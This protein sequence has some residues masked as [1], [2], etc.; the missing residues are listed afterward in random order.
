MTQKK[1]KNQAQVVV[2]GGGV[3]GAS[4]LYHL[5]KAGWKDVVLVE[6][7]ELTHGSTWHSAGGMHTLNGDPNV[8]ALQKYTV[9]LYAEI[10][11]ISGR[12]CGI[13]LTGGL[14]LADSVE[15]MD[16]LRM[17]NARARYLGIDSHLISAA[18]AHEMVPFL[19][20]QYFEGA[21]FDAQEGHVDPSGVTHAYASS[22]Q[23]GGAEIY[24]NTWV[25]AI[26]QTSEGEWELHLHDTKTDEDL[27]TIRCEHFVNAGG[28][29]AR[30]VGRMA[31]IEIPVLAME[32][33][34]LLTEEGPE[35]EGWV[36]QSTLSGFHVMDLGG[37]IYLR[38]EG[39]GLLLGTY[40]P[41]G[42]PWS[43]QTTPWDFGAQ[44]LPPDLERIAA[45]LDVGFQHF[46]IFG[47]VGIKKTIN[48]PFTFAPDGNPLIGPVRGQRGH[49]LACAVMAGLSQGGGV[50]LAM[51]NWMTTGDPGFD[52]WGM[53]NAR[54]GDW[55]T[56]RYTN[57]K[58]RENYSRRFRIS[59]P[60]EELPAARG[61]MRS[62]IHGRLAA[63]NA[64]F[65]AAYGM[66]Y[67]RWFQAPGEEP[68]E[69]PT[70][71]R[72]NA[73]EMVG[74]EV[75][76]VRNRVGI[77]DITSYANYEVTGAGARNWLE[78]MM[79]NHMPDL[80]RLVLTPMLNEGGKLVGD[81]TVACLDTNRFMIIGSGSAQRYHERWFD[82]YAPH[83]GSA[84]IRA[85]GP[86]LAGLCVAGPRSRELLQG[87]VDFDISNEG[88]PF[89]QVLETWVDMVPV[90]LGR[91][92]FTGD[93]GYELW[94]RASYLPQ[95]FDTVM[96][97]GKP[98]GIRPFGIRA[99]ESMR[100]EK[101][102]GTWSQEFRPIYDPYEANM[103]W[104]V[105]LDKDF[106][107]RD[108]A[109]VAASSVR[110]RSL[111]L[112]EVEVAHGTETADAIGD[113]PIWHD[114][115]VVG[116]VTSGDYAHHSARSLAL[117]YV[118]TDKAGSRSGFEIEILGVRRA[119][120][121]LGQAPF[122]PEGKRMRG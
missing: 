104:A 94:C 107:G 87:L 40:E 44:L 57:A 74:Q 45:N 111:V 89:R 16:F 47:E 2:I 12:D 91:V 19:E 52:V 72:S 17:A 82:A 112:F 116:W 56:P 18:E 88:F 60:N 97:A 6:R 36:E 53:D 98:L 117:G 96:E 5:T 100:I 15:R 30:E 62:P 25:H 121:I 48:G 65:G 54:F 119:A 99:L 115:E 71:R 49:W 34:Y 10:E 35:L 3:V 61:L 59:F 103:G 70:F 106:V 68:Y 79:T 9:E 118:P 114:G 41:N 14:V 105:K 38:Q 108:A 84:H 46:P 55:A 90:T 20:P 11:R 32:H 4:V 23:I 33:M 37:E 110:S 50:G 31:G 29:W 78:T 64:V 81:F 1:R 122:D 77:L 67:P 22:A 58:V 76:A 24:R 92:T 109:A 51:A 63:L 8:A 83:D 86:E 75:S 120:S 69:T 42:V 7:R 101:G 28:L 43:P 95:L 113:E 73:F 26:T 80:G 102:W 27:D 21:M 85:L 39:N 66:E 93:L 13:H